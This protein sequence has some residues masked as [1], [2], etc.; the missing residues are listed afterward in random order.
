MFTPCNRDPLTL[1]AVLALTNVRTY[2]CAYIR[3]GLFL[4]AR[5]TFLLRF[6]FLVGGHFP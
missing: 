1:L 6:G 4:D 5:L 3:F 2:W